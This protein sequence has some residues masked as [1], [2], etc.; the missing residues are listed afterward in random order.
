MAATSAADAAFAD[1]RMKARLADTGG[2]VLAGSPAEFRKVIA[3]EIAR[4][5]KVVGASGTKPD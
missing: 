2:D 4:W 1:P 3:E 5:A